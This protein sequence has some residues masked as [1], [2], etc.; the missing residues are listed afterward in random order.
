M[1]SFSKC[2]F[3]ISPPQG[4]IVKTQFLTIFVAKF[5]ILRI[6]LIRGEG[7]CETVAN[8]LFNLSA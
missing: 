7:L 6:E 2:S 1:S 3:G 5:D 4:E 8:F